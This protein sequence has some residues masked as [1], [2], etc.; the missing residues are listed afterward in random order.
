[1]KDLFNSFVRDRPVVAKKVVDWDIKLVLEFVMSGKFA[2]W[3]DVSPRDATLKTV[4]LVA[5]ASR[6]RRSEI[7]ALTRDG[8]RDVWCGSR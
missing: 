7:H 6:K 4:F 5:L 1:M 3:S 8:I 2:S